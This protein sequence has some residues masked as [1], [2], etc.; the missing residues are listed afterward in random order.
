MS[1]NRVLY[2]INVLEKMITRELLKSCNFD[3]KVKPPTA[4]QMRILH[5]LIEHQKESVYQRDLEDILNLR[6]ATVSGVLQT[7]E[8]NGLIKRITS[9]EDHRIKRIV[10]NEEAINSFEKNKSKFYELEYVVKRGISDEELEVFQNILSKMQDN[11]LN[12]K[13]NNKL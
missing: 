3:V 1:D 7:M 11:I 4:T 6:R 8:K 5:Y 12:Y 2:Q 13:K 10:F 9:D